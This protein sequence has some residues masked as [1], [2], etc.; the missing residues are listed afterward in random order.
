LIL[1]A[2][3]GKGWNHIGLYPQQLLD[4]ILKCANTQC[5]NIFIHLD[6][7][8][9]IADILALPTC[10]RSK[11]VNSGYSM[12]SSNLIKLLLLFLISSSRIMILK[13]IIMQITF[14]FVVIYGT[15]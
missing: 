3:K 6:Q 5:G 7:E 13:E 15:R 9:N 11:D 14:D 1:N 8:I 10:N 2:L 4:L 12:P